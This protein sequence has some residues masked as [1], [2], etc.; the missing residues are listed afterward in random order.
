MPSGIPLDGKSSCISRR[1]GN[2]LDFSVFANYTTRVVGLIGS[3]TWI[4]QL[5]P[6][7]RAATILR[8]RT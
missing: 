7:R 4:V 6:R 1:D 5:F 8:R 2:T 3:F